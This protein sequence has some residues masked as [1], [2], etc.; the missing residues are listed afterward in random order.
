MEYRTLPTTDLK[1]SA[2]CLGTM[3]WGKQNSQAQAF[4]QMDYA[5]ERGVNFWDTAEMYPVPADADT[6][7]DTERIIGNWFAK[8]GRRDEV[9]LATK[10]VGPNEGIR[11]IRNGD[12]P[13][14]DA[15]NIRLAVEGSLERL[16]TDYIDL[17]QL[18]WPDRNAPR[19]NTFEYA[20]QDN[21]T[22]TPLAET[23]E[24]LDALVKEGLVRHVGVSNE[25]PWGVMRYLELAKANN[26]ARPI[27][28][29]NHYN[30]L[31]RSF[32]MTLA[33]VSHRE[34]VGLLPYSP[35][36]MGVLSAKYLGGE[37]PSGSR[38]EQFPNFRRY[39]NEM[40]QRAVAAYAEIAREAGLEPDTLA[41]AFVTSRPFVTSNIIG[42]T[43]LEQ[44][45]R[46][47]DSVEVKL[48]EATL[49][50]IDETFKV[51]RNVGR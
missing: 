9:V 28:I 25:T 35:L 13:R 7:S 26:W 22:M 32:E 17:Y 15:K 33:E 24:A 1:V 3:T 21:E 45:K 11:Y 5:L 34:N 4:E 12:L 31:D 23:L 40:G 8:T 37:T 39:D 44:L 16:Q 2:I 18:H 48:S 6:Y 46:N 47:I 20:A 30:L 19:F 41:I 36:A 49:N 10:V 42:A 51:Y 29:Q 14:L 27:T 43:N 38:F 50:K